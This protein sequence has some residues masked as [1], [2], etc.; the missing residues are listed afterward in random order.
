LLVED[1]PT[2]LKLLT[3]ILRPCG[4]QLYTAKGGNQAL[5]IVEKHRPDLILLDIR[6]PDIDGFQVFKK[7][8]AQEETKGIPIIFVSALAQKKYRVKGLSLGAADYIVKPYMKEDIIVSIKEI[9]KLRKLEN[10][11]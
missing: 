1:D 10:V 8:K 5:E 6:L 11:Q 9:L 4:Y 7:L 2:N 3:Y